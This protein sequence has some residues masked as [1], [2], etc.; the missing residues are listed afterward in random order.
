MFKKTSSRSGLFLLELIISILFFSMA[1]AVCIRLFVQ[2]HVMDRDNRNLTQSVKLCENFA[3]VY[4][5]V[6][7]DID[8]LSD[9]YPALFYDSRSIV[10]Y[11]WQDVIS[12]YWLEEYTVAR[13]KRASH[14]QAS[15]SAASDESASTET[16]ESAPTT[17]DAVDHLPGIGPIRDML[18]FLDRDWQPCVIPQT[19]GYVLCI[20]S[21]DTSSAA[22]TLKN[23]S[24][25]VWEYDKMREIEVMGDEAITGI[26]ND[27]YFYQFS[28]LSDEDAIYLLDVTVYV[29][30]KGGADE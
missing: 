8:A 30:G 13:I 28:R 1:S 22:G 18:L 20:V 19:G 16:N 6:G 4:T 24:F 10:V 25:G 26:V 29:P 5:A 11:P 9:V 3:E 15:V 21:F 12:N 2:A 14:M 7:G 27:D 23:A 17:S